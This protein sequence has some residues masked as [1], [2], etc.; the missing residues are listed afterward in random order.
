MK[1]AAF[2]NWAKNQRATPDHIISAKNSEDVA[3][4][5]QMAQR[6]RSRV[7]AVGAGHSFSAAAITE[8]TLIR[9]DGMNTVESYDPASGVVLVGAGM[10]LHDLS[11]ELD[12]RGRALPNL[13]DIDVQTVAGATATGTHGTGLALGNL[14]TGVVGFEIVTGTGDKLWC[15]ADH[16]AELWSAARVGLGAF[17]VITKVA[18]ATVPA[19]TLEAKEGPA[20]FDEVFEGW[21]EFIQS[22]DHAEAIWLPGSDA[23][24]VK[25]NDRTSEEPQPSRFQYLRNK[26]L[27][28]NVGLEVAM[29]TMRRFPTTQRKVG[30]V[31]SGAIEATTTVD[32]SYRIFASPR[33]VR[34]METEY[35]IPVQAV[36]DA[37]RRLRTV[38]EKL[39]APPIFPI[40]VRVSAADDIPL[41]TAHGRQTGWIAVHQYQ[42]M[43]FGECFRAVQAVMDDYDGR[44][45]WGKYHYQTAASLRSRYPQWDSFAEARAKADPQGLFAN[46]YLDRVL[47]PAAP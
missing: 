11:I 16:H 45:H 2:E 3:D 32:K 31:L 44:P 30:Q 21:N 12:G 8:G 37:M 13:G 23:C 4:G 24:M 14:S 27:L 9:L 5:I 41:S 43:A 34:F 47:G 17:G 22:A 20:S 25:R 15:D 42:G 29:R 7:K 19:F 39:D 10:R 26:I 35:A 28:E 18:L 1:Q 36:P 38:I 40:E 46:D 6:N 33:H